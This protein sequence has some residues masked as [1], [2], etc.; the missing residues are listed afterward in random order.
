M[1][2]IDRLRQPIAQKKP[3]SHAPRILYSPSVVSLPPLIR[4]IQ[5]T[6]WGITED[7]YEDL[8]LL[9]QVLRVSYTIMYYKGQYIRT[10]FQSKKVASSWDRYVVHSVEGEPSPMPWNIDGSRPLDR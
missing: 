4:Y 1:H 8:V 3:M 9:D 6:Y 2:K 7:A 5:D 10:D